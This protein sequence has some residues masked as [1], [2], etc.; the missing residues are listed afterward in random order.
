MFDFNDAV[1]MTMAPVLEAAGRFVVV[2]RG[3]EAAQLTA[4]KTRPR[5]GR[6]R[7]DDTIVDAT[8]FDWIAQ[9]ADYVFGGRSVE[10][11]EGDTIEQ[12]RDDGTVETYQVMPADGEAC[13]VPVDPNRTAWR[14]HTR[15]I[16]E[17]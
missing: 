17:T 14:I 5:R 16:S 11:A 6:E 7:A 1:A 13:F 12:T 8:E 4:A 9:A 10:P 2:R 15:L 3:D